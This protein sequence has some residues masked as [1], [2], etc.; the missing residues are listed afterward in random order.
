MSEEKLEY[1]LGNIRQLTETCGTPPRSEIERARF[2]LLSAKNLLEEVRKGNGTVDIADAV[3][4]ICEELAYAPF[5]NYCVGPLPNLFV[6]IK[7]D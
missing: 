4:K 1:I 6:G 3:E 5:K 2:L 7:N